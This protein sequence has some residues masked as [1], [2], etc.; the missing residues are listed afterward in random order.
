MTPV[1]PVW[2]MVA[3]AVIILIVAALAILPKINV[4]IEV[5]IC[6]GEICRPE[7]PVRPTVLR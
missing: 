5:G 6:L 2:V 3:S 7:H 4:N 1:K